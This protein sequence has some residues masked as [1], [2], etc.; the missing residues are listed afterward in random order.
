[1]NMVMAGD[2]HSNIYNINSLDYPYG[3][4]PD[5]SFIAEAVNKSIKQSADRDF[6]FATAENNAQGKFDMIFT[7]PPFGAR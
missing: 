7:N 5:I 4:K 3:A 2:G 1:M 6:K